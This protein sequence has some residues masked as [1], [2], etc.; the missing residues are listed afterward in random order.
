M[1]EDDELD[2]G[3]TMGCPTCGHVDWYHPEMAPPQSGR[4][5]C[6]ECNQDLGPWGELRDRLFP[7][8]AMLAETLAKRS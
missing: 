3:L 2:E 4:T 8:R 6:A 1:E 7:G 5:R